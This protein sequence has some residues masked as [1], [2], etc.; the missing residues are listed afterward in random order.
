MAMNGVD[1]VETIVITNRKASLNQL[2][3]NSIRNA[4]V[5]FFAGGDQCNYVSFFRLNG[6]Q[7]AVRAVY[8]R[9][10]AIGGTSAGQMIQSEFVYD[11]CT[12]STTSAQA[13]ADPYTAS[14]SFTY[15]FFRWSHLSATI[16][17][18]HF[19]Q[20]DRMGRLMSF[21]ARQVKDGYSNAALG[22]AVNERTSVVVDVNGIATVMGNGNGRAYFVLAD[23]MPEVCQRGVPLTYSDF[24][25]WR[26]DQGQTFNLR[27]RP[28]TGF[29]TVSVNNGEIVGNPY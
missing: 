13:L 29:Y 23:H 21:L 6:I 18:S 17:D 16:S 22:I 27:D 25:I 26:V 9:G 10:G 20:R 24:K 19:S 3:L 15:D 14:I 1:S 7:R 11:A 5:I 8:E 4:E 12:G 2:V 28:T